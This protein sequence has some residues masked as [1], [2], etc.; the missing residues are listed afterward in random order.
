MAEFNVAASLLKWHGKH[1][2]H[3]LPWQHPRTPYRVWL[4]EIMLQQTQVSTVIGYFEDF[5]RAFPT[6]ESLARAPSEQV[7]QLWAGL[8]YYSRAR[9]LHKSARICLAE[10]GGELPADFAGLLSLPGIGRSTA[11]AILSQAHGQAY[12]IMDG[13]AKRVLARFHAVSGDVAATPVLNRLWQL[14]ESH[15]PKNHLA[16]YT[17]ALMDLGATLCT[18]SRPDCTRCPL[19]A[20][21]QAYQSGK[22][23]DYPNRK[24]GKAIPK[25]ETY[26][27]IL[28]SKHNEILLEQRPDSGIWGG[29]FSLPEQS[30]ME[31]AGAFA[32]R[33]AQRTGAAT[34]LAA[35]THR[36]SHFQLNIQPLLWRGCTPKARISDNGAY[37]WISCDQLPRLGLPAPIKKLLQVL[38]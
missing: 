5:V 35:V 34:E 7:M 36:F 6:L 3:D 24:P 23:T 21:C 13:N 19:A 31:A 10:H 37:Q 15:L 16:D 11:G 17:Q 8:G 28:L 27:L 20:H 32:R 18:R 22:A 2:R 33:Q 25:R 12:A 9:N 14:A 26:A 4:S 1:G 38:T 30:S 29:L